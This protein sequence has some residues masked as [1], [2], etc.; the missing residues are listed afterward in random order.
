MLSGVVKIL[1]LFIASVVAP[2]VSAC[3]DL[4]THEKLKT[5][6]GTVEV[7]RSV[8][9]GDTSIAV[10]TWIFHADD[11]YIKLYESFNTSDGVA[12]LFGSN[13][14]GSATPVDHLYF[15][16]LQ[17]NKEPLVV[18]DENFFSAS[19][20]T[21]LRSQNGSAFINLGLESGK[22][23][24]AILRSGKLQI[25]TKSASASTMSAKSCAEL[26]RVTAEDCI[27]SPTPT[28]SQCEKNDQDYM[29]NSVSAMTEITILSNQ[30]G[31]NAAALAKVCIKQCQT[32]QAMSWRDFS[33]S[34]CHR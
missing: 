28:A 33:R 17:S 19:C 13:P 26:Y 10:G 5:R 18:T 25:T 16:L 1:L 23:K 6:L 20:S 7:V 11:P 2:I 22:K 31:F 3:D 4:K 14:G 34:V 24:T 32:G 8:D 21:Q 15:L 29:G 9:S 27:E 30:S 12:V